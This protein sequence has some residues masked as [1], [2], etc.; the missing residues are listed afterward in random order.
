MNKL[1]LKRVENPIFNVNLLILVLHETGEVTFDIS[2]EDQ[3]LS[4]KA[5]II[6]EIDGGLIN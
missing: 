5:S 6:V 2:E 3:K 1:L 4:K